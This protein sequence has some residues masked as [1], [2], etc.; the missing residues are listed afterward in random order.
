MKRNRLF[1]SLAAATLSMG[2]A[3]AQNDTGVKQDVKEAGQ[4]TGRAAKKT[5]RKIKKGTKKAINK[6]A[7]AVENGA[8]KVRTKTQ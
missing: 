6:S 4:A 2:M 1:L 8:D 7:G 3:F 5:G